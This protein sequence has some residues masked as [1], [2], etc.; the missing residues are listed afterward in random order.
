MWNKSSEGKPSSQG[1]NS[2]APAPQATAPS[3]VTPAAPVY[4]APA[5]ASAA[6]PNRAAAST[7]ARGIHI[8]GDISGSSDLV[9]DG[10]VHGKIKLP[11]ARV[12]VGSAGRVHADI[13]AR[14]IVIDGSANGNMTAGESL[15][16]GSSG[17][18]HG[19]VLTPRIG[20]DEGARL[21]GKVETTRP[22]VAK[23]SAGSGR[24]ADAESLRPV[25][26]SAAAE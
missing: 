6:A 20:I 25:S 26:A 9:I 3:P 18:L 11:M 23:A 19:S 1:S 2:P 15:R 10:E 5:A 24:A 7:I 16:L 14:E 4:V 8:R 22:A 12:T 17:R 13:E 21:S